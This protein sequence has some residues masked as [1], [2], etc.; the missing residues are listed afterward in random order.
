MDEDAQ[1]PGS[2]TL[3]DPQDKIEDFDWNDLQQRYHDKIAQLDATEHS[4]LG[5]FG[6]LCDVSL[7][8]SLRLQFAYGYRSVSRYGPKQVRLMRS[9]GASNGTVSFELH[10]MLN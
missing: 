8:Q 5:E 2:P 3:S 6:K 7:P 1:S 4:I 9:V 10:I